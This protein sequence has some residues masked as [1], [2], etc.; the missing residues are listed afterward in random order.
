MVWVKICGV[1]CINDA[2]KIT[3][4]N[5]DAIGLVF[6]KTSLRKIEYKKAIR[7]VNF[8][9]DKF[10]ENNDDLKINSIQRKIQSNNRIP[11]IAGVFVNEDIDEVIEKTIKLEL[12][13]VQFSGDEDEKYL[14]DFKRKLD[15]SLR[16]VNYKDNFADI[17]INPER[18]VK[19]V[20]IIKSIRVNDQEKLIK[21]EIIK[22]ILEFG[23][24]ADYFLLD[25]YSEESYGGTGKTFD[26]KAIEDLGNHFPIILAGGLSPENV[27]E[28]VKTV[29]PFGVDASSKLENKPGEKNIEKVRD[30]IK[31]AKF[32]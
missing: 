24:S 7:I 19:S 26:W 1:T 13:F 11:S 15:K 29:N 5:S 10:K 18:R 28:A 20:G 12:D 17:K 8:L 22:K 2:D 30:F 4:L 21:D 25:K 3:S 23:V 31:N 16:S 9:R 6:A 14:D 27:A 32:L